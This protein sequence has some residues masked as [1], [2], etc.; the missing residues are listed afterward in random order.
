MITVQVP[1]LRE[2]LE[3]LPRITEYFLNT[4]SE[5]YSAKPKPLSTAVMNQMM[6]F[7]WPGNLRELQNLIRR[8]VILGTEEAIID[9]LC[10]PAQS[11]ITLDIDFDGQ[12]PLHK[13][14]R[15]AIR[16]L[17]TKVI[18][19]VLRQNNWNRRKTAKALKISYRALLY[20]IRDAGLPG[21]S[22]HGSEI[23]PAALPEPEA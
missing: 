21:R 2:R 14:T 9:D 15:E 16:K 11:G 7:P 3:D 6:R 13:V 10:I 20:K 17:E 22:L 5:R 4:F 18:V 8:Y 12:V 1:P 19:R 23:P